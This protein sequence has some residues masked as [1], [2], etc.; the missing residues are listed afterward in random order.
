MKE[1]ISR[2][3]REEE[4]NPRFLAEYV[5]AGYDSRQMARMTHVECFSLP[6]WEAGMGAAEEKDGAARYFVLFDYR[7]RNPLNRE[8][9]AVLLPL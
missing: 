6:V 3:Y 7:N 5:Q 1:K 8:A 4:K 2:F 9:R